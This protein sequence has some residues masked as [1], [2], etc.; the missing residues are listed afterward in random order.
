[1][2]VPKYRKKKAGLGKVEGRTHLPLVVRW[3]N[4]LGRMGAMCFRWYISSWIIHENTY[5]HVFVS[6]FSCKFQQT[7]PLWQACV[8]LAR[9]LHLHGPHPWVE[10]WIMISTTFCQ[11]GREARWIFYIIDLFENLF[12][13][14]LVK[15]PITEIDLICAP[16]SLAP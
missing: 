8:C 7:K 6:I 16:T 12:S 4:T 14:R 10:L 3:N 1:M 15:K 2:C 13:N 11:F 9:Y 5:L